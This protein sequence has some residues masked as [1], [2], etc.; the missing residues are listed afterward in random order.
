MHG[1]TKKIDNSSSMNR[2]Q[3]SSE[4]KSL[5]RQDQNDLKELAS[6]LELANSFDDKMSYIRPV[7]LR[8]QRRAKYMLDNLRRSG[9]E[10]TIPIIGEEASSAIILLALHSYLTIMEEVSAIFHRLN[11]EVVPLSYLSVLVDRIEV[12]K[13]KTQV[14]GTIIYDING[15]NY[16]VPIKNPKGLNRRRRG[17][18]LGELD[19]RGPVTQRPMD[20][21][22]YLLN[23]AF[24]DKEITE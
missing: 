4:L 17:Y 5:A 2:Q 11:K 12:I 21:D 1:Q 24:M 22:Q 13:S 19:L 23:F 10:P 14:L 3:L 20:E 7:A 9:I 15:T 8:C 16:L 18:G 6:R